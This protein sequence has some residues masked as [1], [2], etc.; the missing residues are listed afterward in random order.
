MEAFLCSG[1]RPF[2]D[3]APLKEKHF[4]P[5]ADFL[6]GTLRS[7]AE[8]LRFLE[9]SWDVRST[10]THN[11]TLKNRPYLGPNSA[12][13]RGVVLMTMAPV[14]GQIT[15]QKSLILKSHDFFLDFS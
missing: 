11:I 13:P 9:V 12:I 8:F 1:E 10:E 4:C 7:V 15:S 2:Q 6:F 5:F 3:L 14:E